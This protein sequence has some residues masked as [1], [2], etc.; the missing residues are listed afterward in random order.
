[1]AK[2]TGLPAEQRRTLARLI[3]CWLCPMPRWSPRQTPPSACAPPTGRWT[4]FATRI[5]CWSPFN[6]VPRDAPSPASA[7][8]PS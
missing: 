4:L 7:I 5:L 6:K 1:M 3:A 2:R 8:A